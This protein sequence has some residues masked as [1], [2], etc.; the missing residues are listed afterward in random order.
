MRNR[1]LFYC[2]V[3][4]IVFLLAGCSN[5]SGDGSTK[6]SG[7]AAAGAPISGTVYLKDS[8]NPAKELS[9]PIAAD[10]SFSF[11]VNG[12]TAPFLLKT[13][14]TSNRNNLTLYSFAA[15]AGIANINPLSN[16]ALAD[17][18]G[19]DDLAGLYISPNP[20][21]M[22][23][24]MNRLPNAIAT[25]QTVLQPTLTKLGVASAHFIND[26]F[27]T[28]HQGLDLL[29]DMVN[30]TAFSGVVT[31]FDRTENSYKQLCLSDFESASVNVIAI[32]I[33]A[34]GSVAIWPASRTI[35]PNRE[36]TFTAV[37][38]G[39]SNQQVTWSVVESNGGTITSSGLY[40][41][42]DTPGTY[43]VK[44]TSAVDASKS[45]TA[46]ITVKQRNVINLV[47]SGAG[48]FDFQ[49][50]EL[51]N[52]V[53]VQLTISYNTSILSNPQVVAGA[54]ATGATLTT[55]TSIPGVLK[56]TISGNLIS[57]AGSLAS[58]SFDVQGSSTRGITGGTIGISEGTPP[59]TV[60][61]ACG[62]NGSS[63]PAN[64]VGG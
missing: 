11:D 27:V 9:T 32:P 25:I 61:L 13:V 17:A 31:I 8:S 37:I 47:Q 22:Q 19:D 15:T 4:L 23:V 63:M 26:P 18:S 49:G 24:I 36:T 56:V 12:L 40:R 21:K 52:I 46:T 54:L 29:F 53:N 43:H 59:A 42:P 64:S 62:N 39:A 6:L 7:V 41:A 2:I 51:T 55:D 48:I 10:G 38:I 60:P 1:N 16:L 44:A 3:V 5:G 58:I 35:E 33:P 45:T 50:S 57:G 14:D 34:T 28:N 30:F 20:I